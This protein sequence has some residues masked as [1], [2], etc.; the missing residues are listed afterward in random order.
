MAFKGHVKKDRS[1]G[2]VQAQV[3]AVANKKAGGEGLLLTKTHVKFGDESDDDY[4]DLAVKKTKED[5]GEGE[6]ESG[7]T[8][9]TNTEEQEED[10]P[11]VESNAKDDM[12]WFKSK[13]SS[14]KSLLEETED[15][16]NN[17]NEK[18]EDELMEELEQE[19]KQEEES[20]DLLDSD[21]EDSKPTQPTEPSQPAPEMIAETGRLFLR[22][23]A[24][25]CTEQDLHNLFTRFG[26]ISEIH[27]PIDKLSKKPKGYAFIMFLLPEHAVKA[28]AELDRSIFQGRILEILPGKEKLEKEEDEATMDYK[29]KKELQKKKQGEFSWNSLFMNSDAVAESMAKKLG[30]KKSDILDPEAENMAVR[31]A[32][33]ETQVIQDTKSYLESHGVTLDAFE[34]GEKT[35]SDKIMLVKNIPFHSEVEE[36]KDLFGRFGDLGRVLLPPSKTIALVEYLQVNEAKYAFKRLA[37]TKF[38]NLPLYLEWAPMHTFKEE[39]DPSK[40]ITTTTVT[41]TT[42]DATDPLAISENTESK[43]TEDA[44]TDVPTNVTTL[45]VKNLNFSTT[46]STLQAAFS[47]SPGL[48]TVKIATKTAK[49]TGEKLSMGFGFVE[50][51]S[52][53]S[54]KKAL[55]NLQGIVLDGH[56]L[57]LKV[58]QRTS[59]SN[60]TTGKKKTTGT[61]EEI[62]PTGTKLIIRNVPF[63]ATKKE[64]RELFTPFGQIKS[65]R[66]PKKFDNT[67]RGFAFIDFLTKQEAANAYE[68]LHATH[69]YGRHL[70]LEWAKE[71]DESI[72]GMRKRSEEQLKVLNSGG[73]KGNK[74]QR[75]NLDEDVA[76]M[77]E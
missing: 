23:L 47:T 1:N 37:Y 5:E 49:G 43:T 67:H 10:L 3:V 6:N 75:V 36:L 76:D 64:L 31:L 32:L 2:G 45:F 73:P 33:A 63:E 22:N 72:E 30:L 26:P 15:G 70:V 42:K 11:V 51:A 17:D 66:I 65:L 55:T 74:R 13:L 18:Q 46:E 7:K 60:A 24:Y 40:P 57:E 68:S 48:R 14:G 50:F 20:R 27:I 8:E 4:Q 38:K 9:E 41:T 61:K 77:E 21:D 39:Y 28:F 19:L 54:A 12:E 52:K 59:S 69:L 29:K 25:S 62:K 34:K 16:A 71:E 44:N 58:S 53:E 35:R 56:K